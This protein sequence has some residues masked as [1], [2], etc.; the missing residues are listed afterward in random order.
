[1][2]SIY[3]LGKFHN[4]P[5]LPSRPRGL[6]CLHLGTWNV[7]DP[8]R[9]RA[10]QAVPYPVPFRAWNSV[11]CVEVVPPNAEAGERVL[12]PLCL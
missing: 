12:R 8:S 3:D 7:C 9:G 6:R 1:M 4:L 10:M 2:F 11:L 5:H